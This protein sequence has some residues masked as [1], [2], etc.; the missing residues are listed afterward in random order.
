M[1][2]KFLTG[3]T[4]KVNDEIVGTFWEPCVCQDLDKYLLKFQKYREEKEKGKI[5]HRYD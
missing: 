3:E 2:D 4:V 1:L 5:C